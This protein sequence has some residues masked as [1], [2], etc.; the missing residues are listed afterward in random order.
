MVVTFDI[1]NLNCK[2]VFQDFHKK[3]NPKTMPKRTCC[4]DRFSSFF[5]FMIKIYL[6][7]M[8]ESLIKLPINNTNP[9][10]YLD[11]GPQPVFRFKYFI[12]LVYPTYCSGQIWILTPGTA[13]RYTDYRAFLWA[14]KIFNHISIYKFGLSVCLFVWVSV[15]IQ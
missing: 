9:R 1:S 15:C 14:N 7:Y 13:A 3:N 10:Q 6:S 11:W 2:K 12:I 5:K 4:S 8:T